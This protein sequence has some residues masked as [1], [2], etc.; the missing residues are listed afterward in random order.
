MSIKRLSRL[1]AGYGYLLT[2]LEDPF[3]YLK[4]ISEPHHCSPK[5]IN[6][7]IFK[8]PESLVRLSLEGDFFVNTLFY[9][10]QIH[11]PTPLI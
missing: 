9:L 11:V 10:L 8:C 1:P 6:L 4:P 7:F 3:K 2:K 5:P